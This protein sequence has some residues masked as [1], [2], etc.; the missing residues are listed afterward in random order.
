MEPTE[1]ATYEIELEVK[2]RMKVKIQASPNMEDL[3][4]YN[5]EIEEAVYNEICD[6]LENADI[7]VIRVERE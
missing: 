3:G 2:V 7:E 6:N 4:E 5:E 1:P